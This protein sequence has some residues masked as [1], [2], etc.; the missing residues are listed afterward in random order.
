MIRSYLATLALPLI[1]VTGVFGMNFGE[2]PELGPRWI[3]WILSLLL[4]S[5]VPVMLYLFRKNRWL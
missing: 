1:I 2:N 3:Y 4:V 5:A